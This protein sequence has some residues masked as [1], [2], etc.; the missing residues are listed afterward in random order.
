MLNRRPASETGI[1]A[2]LIGNDAFYFDIAALIGVIMLAQSYFESRVKC[3]MARAI[4]E[5]ATNHNP[6]DVAV[7]GT[8]GSE[9]VIPAV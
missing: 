1:R 3:K 2:A 4:R 9:T 5:L 8:D 7:V 6:Q